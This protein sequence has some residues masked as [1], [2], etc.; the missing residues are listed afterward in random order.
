MLAHRLLLLVAILAS[1]AVLGVW[2]NQRQIQRVL[3]R[4][5]DAVGQITGA[6]QQTGLPLTVDG[7][8]PRL[9]EQDLS[10]NLKWQGRDGAWREHDNVPVT[11]S[12][13]RT[14]VAGD[15]VRLAALP[16]RAIDD[17]TSPVVRSDVSARLESLQRWLGIAGYI[18]LASW[19]GFAGLTIWLRRNAAAKLGRTEVPLRRTVLGIVLLFGGSF[20]AFHAWS[21]ARGYEAMR[22]RGLEATATILDAVARK[23]GD[24]GSMSYAVRL[25]WKGP[26][27]AV[28]HYGPTA[29]SEEFWKKVTRDGRL[30]QRETTI[31]YLPDE[32]LARPMIVEDAPEQSSRSRFGIAGGVVAMLIGAGL[33]FSAMRHMRRAERG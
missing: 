3:D 7:W 28:H 17:G 30:V 2:D 4:G 25:S 9:V 16:I 5:Y 19:A 13:A 8:R 20:M 32:T 22:G 26:E 23:Q 18:A 12:L 6:R 31:R 24:S 10:V 15:Q 27:G 21:D 1:L 33:L 29:I 14:I 11:P